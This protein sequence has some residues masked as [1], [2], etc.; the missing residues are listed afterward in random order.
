MADKPPCAEARLIQ[1]EGFRCKCTLKPENLLQSHGKFSTTWKAINEPDGSTVIVK[2]M[3]NPVSEKAKSRI[4]TETSLS[5]LHPALPGHIET[6]Y[7]GTEAYIVRPYID[8]IDL[9]HFLKTHQGKQWEQFYIKLIVNLT[10]PL[11]ALHTAGYCHADIKPPNILI[12]CQNVND[13]NPGSFPEAVLLDTGLARSFGISGRTPFA[14]QYAAPEQV[15]GFGSLT[16]ASSDVYSLGIVLYECMSGDK[17]FYH[18][19][20][21]VMMNLMIASPL[22]ENSRLQPELFQV[23]QKACFKTPLPKPPAF[24]QKQQLKSML[25]MACNTRYQDAA[26]FGMALKQCIM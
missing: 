17:P 26:G 22:P 6:V 9:Q 23:L 11:Q 13:L 5:G 1:I 14:V 19:N 2:R 25:E 15:L 8:G 16:G 24:Y 7:A 18:P 10:E 21:E 12:K 4:T 3:R 20:P